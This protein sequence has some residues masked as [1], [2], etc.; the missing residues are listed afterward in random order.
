LSDA[1]RGS[2][3]RERWLRRGLATLWTF[4]F[5][6]GGFA[7]ASAWDRLVDGLVRVPMPA[8]SAPAPAAAAAQT[9]PGEHAVAEARRLLDS[10]NPSEALTAL[11]AIKPQEPVYPFSLQLRE[12]AVRALERAK[13]MAR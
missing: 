4:L 13:A 9:T 2:E 10:G 12:E 8:P 5:A 7:V 11:L 6:V 3:V 1:G